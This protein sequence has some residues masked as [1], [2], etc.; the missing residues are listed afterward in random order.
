[1]KRPVRGV[2]SNQ[3]EVAPLGSVRGSYIICGHFRASR[4]PGGGESNPPPGGPATSLAGGAILRNHPQ[5][6]AI[7][8]RTTLFP[9]WARRR[10]AP[11]LPAIA[12][13]RQTRRGLPLG[14]VLFRSNQ[15]QSGC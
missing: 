2:L 8:L 11:R 13:S 1:M 6:L 12:S 14:P 15:Q 5:I 4:H 3:Q 9:V 10:A 7:N